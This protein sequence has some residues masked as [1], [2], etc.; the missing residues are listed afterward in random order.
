MDGGAGDGKGK[1]RKARQGKASI[2]R[3]KEGR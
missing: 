1:E 2:E 3:R